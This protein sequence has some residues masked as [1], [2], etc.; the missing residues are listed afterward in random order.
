MVWIYSNSVSLADN[1]N[2]SFNEAFDYLLNQLCIANIDMI[3][4][5]ESK[6][7]R[8]LI[9]TDNENDKIICKNGKIFWKS[10]FLVNKNFK[11][12]LIDYYKPMGI[13]VKGPNQILRK[14]KDNSPTNKWIIEL[15]PTYYSMN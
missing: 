4:N 15:M 10:K 8:F 14:N 6:C 13:Y 2:N 5:Q 9:S 12:R 3:N 1:Q 11:K 7:Y